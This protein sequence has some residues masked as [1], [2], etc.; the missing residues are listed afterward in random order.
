MSAR[1]AEKVHPFILTKSRDIYPFL[2][3]KDSL[4]FAE[5]SREEYGGTGSSTHST[6]TLKKKKKKKVPPR[7][8]NLADDAAKTALMEEWANFRMSQGTLLSGT[9]AGEDTTPQLSSDCRSQEPHN[10]A[11]IP[12]SEVVEPNTSHPAPAS[13]HI[14]HTYSRPSSS[15]SNQLAEPLPDSDIPVTHEP[16][17]TSL[18]QA[19]GSVSHNNLSDYDLRYP[20]SSPE[21]IHSMIEDMAPLQHVNEETT[22]TMVQAS[23]TLLIG[24]L[25]VVD[26]P[27]QLLA[28]DSKTVAL[29]P[30]SSPILS[31]LDILPEK[32]NSASP[33]A[34]VEPKDCL[35]GTSSAVDMQFVVSSQADIED[36]VLGFHMLDLHEVLSPWVPVSPAM[37]SIYVPP[38]VQHLFAGTYPSCITFDPN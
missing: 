12:S 7:N 15:P 23:H 11:E 34:P 28:T 3:S 2:A 32:M 22:D 16:L 4:R 37:P 31:K 13:D 30:Q 29:H 24:S 20:S 18:P 17:S 1:L 21:N 27:L 36:V 9:S 33:G 14:E 10:T 35:A 38:A 25:E 6:S 8:I 19:K 26:Q 5:S